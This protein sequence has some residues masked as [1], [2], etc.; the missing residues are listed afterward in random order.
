[1]SRM[2]AIDDLLD[3][4]GVAEVLGLSHPNTVSVYQHRY[5]DMP[6]PVIDLGRGRVKLWLRPEIE[7]WS[8]RQAT[9][10]RSRRGTNRG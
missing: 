1:M 2:V 9:S 10:G 5:A 3:A 8:A 7:D 6:R 4:H